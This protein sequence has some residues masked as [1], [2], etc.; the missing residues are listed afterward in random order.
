MQTDKPI[1][2]IETGVHSEGIDF[3]VSGNKLVPSTL[4]EPLKVKKYDKEISKLNQVI[5]SLKLKKEGLTET[6]GSVLT[7]Y[8]TLEMLTEIRIALEKDEYKPEI[9]Y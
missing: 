1:K 8:K 9:H 7:D 3:I 6:H 4:H 2:K 5:I